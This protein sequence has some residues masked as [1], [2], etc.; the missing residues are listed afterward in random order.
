MKRLKD[1]LTFEYANAYDLSSKKRYSE[2]KIFSANGDLNKRWYVY[3]SFRN[4]QSGKLER[5]TPIYGGANRYH[6]KAQRLEVLTMLRK[7][8]SHLLGQGFSPYEDNTHLVQTNQNMETTV[9]PGNASKLKAVVSIEKG[10]EMVLKLKKATLANTSYADFNSRLQRFV[11]WINQRYAL[12]N[13]IEVIT[14][15]DVIAYLNH[16]LENSSARNRNNTRVDLGSF[17]QTLKDNELVS[18]NFVRDI[19]VLKTTPK[20]HKNYSQQQVDA[21]FRHLQ[22]E[23]PMLLLFIQFI[24]YNFLRPIE[25]C[26]LRVKDLNIAEKTLTVQAKNKKVKV[27]RIPEILLKELPNLNEMS[28]EHFLF[29]PKGFGLPWESKETNK[30]DYF[31]KRF[32]SVVK[33][34]FSLGEH[35]GLYSFRHTFITK[36][37]KEL[38]K[39]ATPF[40]V[41]SKLMLITGHST[42]TALEKYLR[43]IDAQLPDDYS[44]FFE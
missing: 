18:E 6:T 29:T 5:Q 13:P 12:T 32:N 30:R 34:Y 39:N 24:S 40:E 43:S 22:K 27:K 10:V 36:L 3:F 2:P 20:R 42:M 35:Y 16:V 33:K 38:N 7:R 26:R 31:T 23:D 19:N 1:F 44:Q 21:I 9:Q 41:K 37:Y 11:V 28:Q 4:P 8:L 14:K 15:G 25:V 17:F